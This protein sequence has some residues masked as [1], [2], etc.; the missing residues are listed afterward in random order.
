MARLKLFVSGR[1]LPSGKKD[2]ILKYANPVAIHTFVRNLY[3]K[4]LLLPMIVGAQDDSS[5]TIADGD[6]SASI[7]GNTL[8]EYVELGYTKLHISVN[9]AS[10]VAGATTIPISDILIIAN[11]GN[12]PIG[13]TPIYIA[14]NAVIGATVSFNLTT[15]TTTFTSLGGD[16]EERS[17][18]LS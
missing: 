12:A 14:A 9:F 3:F 8:L 10:G 5:D 17:I 11:Q 6:S 7:L 4:E 13:T 15:T 16:L 1:T 18:K 2:S